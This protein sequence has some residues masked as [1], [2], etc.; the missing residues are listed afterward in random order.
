[1][2]RSTYHP[3]MTVNHAPIREPNQRWLHCMVHEARDKLPKKRQKKREREEEVR[4]RGWSRGDLVSAGQT[5][6]CLDGSHWNSGLG[7]PTI[8]FFSEY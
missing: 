3:S 7:S 1:M 4:P 8:T 5:P 6:K 2:L